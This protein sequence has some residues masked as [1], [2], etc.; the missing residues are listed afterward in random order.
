V[1]PHEH[2]RPDCSTLIDRQGSH[3]GD[4]TRQHLTMLP[5]PPPLLIGQLEGTNLALYTG[6]SF[7]N[8]GSQA[9]SELSRAFK[10]TYDSYIEGVIRLHL[11]SL[12]HG[13]PVLHNHTFT[14]GQAAGIVDDGPIELHRVIALG[15]G[16]DNMEMPVEHADLRDHGFIEFTPLSIGHLAHVPALE[17][18]EV[19]GVE[20]DRTSLLLNTDGLL[21]QGIQDSTQSGGSVGMVKL[22]PQHGSLLLRAWEEPA[23]QPHGRVIAEV[24]Q[25]RELVVIG[26]S[27]R[28]MAAIDSFRSPPR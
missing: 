20:L 6:R 8:H 21:G 22:A 18:R 17:L 26:F 28:P 15:H 16:G 10:A 25:G 12:V 3:F 13:V 2:S 24:F 1:K 23:G 7:H 14:P 11:E 9:A 5:N 27:F 4:L 19:S